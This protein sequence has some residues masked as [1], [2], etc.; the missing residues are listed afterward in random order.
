MPKDK[1]S[2]IDD[3]NKLRQILD[4][5]LDEKYKSLSDQ[6]KKDLDSL[7]KRLS[8]DASKTEKKYSLSDFI[9]KDYDCLKP[10]VTIHQK[11]EKIAL[12]KIDKEIVEEKKDPEEKPKGESLFDNVELYEIDTK[13]ASSNEF[14]EVISKEGRD[15]KKEKETIFLPVPE[16]VAIEETEKINEDLP[17]FKSVEDEKDAEEKFDFETE[18]D[19]IFLSVPDKTQKTKESEPLE[20]QIPEFKEIEIEKPKEK[21]EI[22]PPKLQKFKIIEKEPEPKIFSDITDKKNK[23]KVF[24]EEEVIK[25]E[26]FHS[27][28]DTKSP[29][30]KKGKDD[31]KLRISTFIED[32]KYRKRKPQVDEVKKPES[33]EIKKQPPTGLKDR[34]KDILSA[35]KTKRTLSEQEIE[36]PVVKEKI[37]EE[38]KQVEQIA[39]DKEKS[40]VYFS[41]V[42]TK[43]EDIKDKTPESFEEITDEKLAGTKDGSL[44]EKNTEEMVTGGQEKDE[45]SEVEEQLQPKTSSEINGEEI[46]VWEPVD[47]LDF[48]EETKKKFKEAKQLETVEEPIPVK[49]QKIA[50]PV[51]PK[52]EE[53]TKIKEKFKEQKKKQKEEKKANKEKKKLTKIKLKEQER[54]EKIKAKNETI[55]AKK[56]EK[57]AL[58]N[59]HERKIKKQKKE[60]EKA[61]KS[62]IVES[63]KKKKEKQE[64]RLELIKV[65]E[66]KIA[67]K[68]K[69]I[70]SRKAEKE[71]KI[72][73]KQEEKERLLEEKEKERLKEIEA[74]NE[75][76]IAKQKEKEEQKLKKIQEKQ[77]AIEA[78]EKEKEANIAEKENRLI[79]K[80]KERDKRLDD[81]QK[82]RLKRIEE[83][84][85]L[86]LAKQKE[87]EELKLKKIQEKQA[88]IE[89]KE[90][91]KEAY[92]AERGKK[93]EEKRL[94]EKKKAVSE[95]K[96][97]LKQKVSEK[98]LKVEDIEITKKSVETLQEVEGE[99]EI[100]EWT[101][102]EVGDDEEIAEWASYDVV[103][104]DSTITNINGDSAYKHG[105][106]LLYKKEIEISKNKKR[107]IHFFSK[108][109]P[110]VGKPVA[111]PKGY[112]VKINKKTKVPYL[113][114]RK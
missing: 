36:P 7:R 26:A 89:A 52:A 3:I 2:K 8:K 13:D 55:E 103:E 30:K 31:L 106:Y 43:D 1:K 62:K 114:K 51:L 14:L 102:Y 12:K 84:N 66:D 85:V 61:L 23:D 70:E 75:L 63:E 60:K 100:G 35:L 93:K 68:Q 20:E 79:L 49:E 109:N 6:E 4:N 74:K 44:T 81:K 34:K 21:E 97:L 82:E 80:K 69:E 94:K 5:P 104:E 17:E 105:E 110:E 53:K 98:K 32:R 50:G 67:A 107:T 9:P 76:K 59:E 40:D 77:A 72:K 45:D 48:K 58:A 56:R 57:E 108:E 88:S 27:K 11:E 24:L 92:I 64:H 39:P 113:K 25:E 65:K 91:E 38:Q 19:E 111:L 42:D 96:E 33:E 86:Q 46:S 22:K 99:E 95:E 15:K 78:K 41:I 83:K 71:K 37:E 73:Q 54:L 87:K 90:K 10:R 16:Q 112:D 28:E 18:K 47:D 101:S 29:G